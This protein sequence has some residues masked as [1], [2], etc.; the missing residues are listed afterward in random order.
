VCS[1]FAEAPP[2][3]QGFYIVQTVLSP[4]GG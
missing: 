1:A 4:N 3:K 2:P